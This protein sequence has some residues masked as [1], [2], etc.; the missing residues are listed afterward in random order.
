MKTLY[1]D[2]AYLCKLYWQE[3]GSMQVMAQAAK[4][5][6]IA[7]CLHGHAEFCS[8]G[9]RKMR[10][11]AAKLHDFENVLTQFQAD[12]KANALRLL[13]ITEAMIARIEYVYRKAPTGV[14][15]RAADALHLACASEN[16]FV[17]AYSND[18]HLLA[19]APLFGLRGVNVI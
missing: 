10:E 5:D 12:C 3:D 16:G 15:L 18:R 9:H 1:F 2:T 17:E 13:P 8:I 7:C 19:A 11:S 4:A 6:V 14:F